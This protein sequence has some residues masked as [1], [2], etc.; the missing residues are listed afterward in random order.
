[1]LKDGT[2]LALYPISLYKF[3]TEIVCASTAM[4]PCG[5]SDDSSG[6]VGGVKRVAVKRLPNPPRLQLL[7]HIGYLFLQ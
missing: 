1:M 3:R 6:K 7:V 4:R 5:A 2:I